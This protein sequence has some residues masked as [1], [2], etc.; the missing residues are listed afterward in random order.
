MLLE[1]INQSIYLSIYLS[2]NQSLKKACR[3]ISRYTSS[4]PARGTANSLFTPIRLVAAQFRYHLVS[5]GELRP[6]IL[7][8]QRASWAKMG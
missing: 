7:S 4:P 1:N 8:P 5:D 6:V 3:H 2:V